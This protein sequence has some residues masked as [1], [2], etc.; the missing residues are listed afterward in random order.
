MTAVPTAFFA[1]TYDEVV[2]LAVDARAHMAAPGGAADAMVEA[3]CGLRL[4]AR[5]THMMAWLLRQRAVH[6]GE[7]AATDALDDEPLGGIE[8]CLDEGAAES[9]SPALSALMDR[10]L[11]LYVRIARLDDMV[12]RNAA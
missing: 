8:E 1:K 12:R 5:I 3:R 9:C 2:A 6:A 7:I 10:S 11:R 4:V